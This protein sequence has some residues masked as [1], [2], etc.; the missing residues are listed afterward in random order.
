MAEYK[1]T[2]EEQETIIRGTAGGQEWEIITADARTIRRIEKQGYKPD[3]RPNPWG[4]VSFTLP[5]E[6]VKIVKAEKRKATGRPF[7][8][9][10]D[11]KPHG[12]TDESQILR[13]A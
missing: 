4:Y 1:L 13:L 10:G 9:S 2:R 12:K 5:F 8:S 6:K 3:D 11:A 7:Q